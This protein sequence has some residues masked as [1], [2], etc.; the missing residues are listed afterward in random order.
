VE[1]GA[2]IIA[3]D[4]PA[5]LDR[6]RWGRFLRADT[7]TLVPRPQGSPGP[8][9]TGPGIYRCHGTILLPDGLTQAQ[10][11]E[12]EHD[13]NDQ[14]DEINQPVHGA[15]PFI[16]TSAKLLKQKTVPESWKY[17]VPDEMPGMKGDSL[18]AKARLCTAD[19]LRRCHVHEDFE[20]LHK[21]LVE[22]E[23]LPEV[24]DRCD[25]WSR[26]S[27]RSWEYASGRTEQCCAKSG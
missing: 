5:R 27:G 6:L 26:E 20:R 10:E 25:A 15:T 8:G 1:A 3:T 19:R 4:I 13:H 21:F 7:K 22:P 12:D 17:W 9:Y 11:R 18:K 14:A 24:S 23:V 16:S 2:G